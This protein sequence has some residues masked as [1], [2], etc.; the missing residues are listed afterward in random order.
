ME[1]FYGKIFPTTCIF[2]G[3]AKSMEQAT[4]EVTRRELFRKFGKA[5][6]GFAALGI[7]AAGLLKPKPVE[8]AGWHSSSQ[9]YRNSL[10]LNWAWNDYGQTFAPNCKE[11]VRRVVKNASGGIVNIPS[12][13][14]D[15]CTW[16]WSQDVWGYNMSRAIQYA[17]PG[18][19][20][21]MRLRYDPWLHTAIVSSMMS[22]RV[23]FIEC[24]V[25]PKNGGKVGYR[26]L[27]FSDFYSGANITCYSIYTIL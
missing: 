20:V 11:W 15:N 24:N 6:I 9:A 22:D 23:G 8:A 2:D 17:Q 4:S 19:I 7:G 16:A 12:T 3:K 10:I 27:L 1:S 18:E 21:Q 5:G 14:S 26:E 13:N 25:V